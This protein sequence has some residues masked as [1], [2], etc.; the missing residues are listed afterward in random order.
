MCQPPRGG[1]PCPC[2]QHSLGL[3]LCSPLQLKDWVQKLLM[4]LRHPTLPLLDLQEIMTSVSGRI[5]APVEKAVRR[6]MA[7]YAS[8]ITSVLCQFPSQQVGAPHPHPSPAGN[9]SPH[10]WG[11]P[12]SDQIGLHETHLQPRCWGLRVFFHAFSAGSQHFPQNNSCLEEHK[13]LL[14]LTL[15][16]SAAEQE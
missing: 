1:R 12:V 10:Q 5:P 3:T 14:G 13:Q 8:N 7:Q 11:R 6:V 15:Y 16:N 2:P 9:P 4:T